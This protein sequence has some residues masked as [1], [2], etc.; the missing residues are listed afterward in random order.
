M[1]NAMI[2]APQPDAVETGALVLKEGGNAVDA[3]IACAFVQ[4]VVDPL[5]CGIAGFGSMQLYLPARGIHELIDFHG[6]VPAAARPDMWQDMIVGETDDGFGFILKGAVNDIGYQAITVPGS[7]KA[8]YQAHSRYGSLPWNR[9]VEPAIS[10][11][12]KGYILAPDVYYY[13]IS[14]EGPGRAKVVDRLR[15]SAAGRDAYCDGTGNPLPIGSLIKNPAMA[16][17]LSLIVEQGPD[18]FYRGEIARMIDA[19]MKTNGG[20][21]SA[22]DLADYETQVT[23]PLWGEYRGR[24]FSTNRPPGGG[25]MLIEMLNI[26]ENFDLASIGHNTPEYMRVVAEA[27]KITTTDKDQHVGDP[28][29][30]PVPVDRL[31]AKSYAGSLAD[32]I[33]RGE[34]HHVERMGVTESRK[35]THI[36]LIDRDGNA[37]S[38]T[39]SLGMMS[40]VITQGLGFMY[41]GCMAVFDPRPGRTGSIAPG[42]SRFSSICPTIL[43][44]DQHP[45][46]IIGAPGGTRIAMG[47]LQVILNVVDFGMPIGE[48][49]RAPRFS[50]TS[51]VIDVCARIPRYAYADLEAQGYSVHRSPYS[52][53]I[54]SVH[55]IR[56]EEERLSGSAD[57]PYGGGMAL[58]V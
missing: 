15:Y 27:M 35:T 53:E 37:V 16:K 31:T 48:A 7:L 17:T 20:I 52:Y 43:F 5:M 44:E 11:A 12:T 47:V 19:D 40:G 38:M 30:T 2:V 58:E 34:K 18:V 57:I 32:K 33:K 49:V 25:I 10:F 41:N 6:K 28:A 14:D 4:T 39:H 1:N 42:K 36:S 45:A 51:D 46:L 21:L 13:W 29:F 9:V 50:A 22:A 55:A 8:F 54:A 3:A 23:E 26:L 56:V 24:H